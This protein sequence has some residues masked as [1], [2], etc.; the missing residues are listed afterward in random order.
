MQTKKKILI[1]EDD[2]FL[3]K[4]LARQLEDSGFE[5]VLAANGKEGLAKAVANPADLVLL[6]VMLPDVDGFDILSQ[7]KAEGAS[8]DAPVI[9]ISNLGQAEDIQQSRQLGAVD[10]IVKSDL[11][12][13]ELVKKVKQYIVK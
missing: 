5:T 12:L 3:S 4:L 1:I 13:D 6:D 7:L 10:H 8:K 2:V 11:S 9:I